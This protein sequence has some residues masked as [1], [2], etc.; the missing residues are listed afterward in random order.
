MVDTK[1]KILKPELNMNEI[2]R[3]T[4]RI[5]N[6]PKLQL[7]LQENGLQDYMNQDIKIRPFSCKNKNN[8]E[9]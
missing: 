5:E 9:I 3:E 8:N 6:N 2:L 4:S 7:S 1:N